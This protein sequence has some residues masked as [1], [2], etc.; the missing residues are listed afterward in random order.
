VAGRTLQEFFK[1]VAIPHGVL[2]GMEYAD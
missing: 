2:A 1:K